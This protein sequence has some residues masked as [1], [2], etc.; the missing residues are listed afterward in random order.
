[1]RKE[2]EVNTKNGNLNPSYIGFREDIAC[3]VPCSAKRILDIGCSIGAAGG[4]LKERNSAYVCGIEMDESMARM[5]RLKLDKVI[6]GDVEQLDLRKELNDGQFDCIICADIL[7]HLKEPW[8]LLRTIRTFLS[9]NG[10][11]I[12]SIPNIRH[13]TTIRSLLFDGYWPYRE[14]GIHD[15]S[16]LRFFALRNIKEMFQDSGL[17]I[18][19]VVRKYR[20]IERPHR[21]N[22]ISR[23]FAVPLLRDLLAFQYLIVAIKRE[24]YRWGNGQ[25]DTK[26]S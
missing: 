13:F 25:Y 23:W 9:D 19:K 22:K 17:T 4:L 20:L 24:A 2:C 5:A 7:E 18:V 1:M 14:R 3:L 15:K 11:V 16:H 26:E 8:R 10:V 12:A 6:T 21:L